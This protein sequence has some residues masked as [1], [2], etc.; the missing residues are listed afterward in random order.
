MQVVSYI[1]LAYLRDTCIVDY[2]FHTA[3]LLKKAANSLG[4]YG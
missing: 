1:I 3:A 2:S 4:L